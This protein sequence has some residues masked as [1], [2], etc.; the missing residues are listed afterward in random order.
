M[1]NQNDIES[2]LKLGYFLNYKNPRYSFDFSKVDKNKYTDLSFNELVDTGHK[3]FVESIDKVFNENEKHVVPISGGLD[4]RAILAT[5]L[6]FTEASNIRTY[7]FGTPNTF[8]FDIGNKIAKNIGTQHTNYSLIDYK[9]DIEELIDISNRVDHQTIL[10]HHPPIWDILKEFGDSTIW[11]GFL[12]GELTDAR[13]TNYS[14][15]DS[16][17]NLFLR[18]NCYSKNSILTNIDSFETLTKQLSFQ[19]N[20]ELT[21]YEVLDYLNRQLKFIAPHVL[22]KGFKFETPFLDEKV[23]NFYWSIDNKYRENK[24]LYKEILIN[25]HE[26]LFSYPVKDNAGASL[27]DSRAKI[28]ANKVVSKVKRKLSNKNVNV[29]YLDFNYQIREKEDLKNIIQFN[30][31]DLQERDI[32]N[33]IDGRKIYKDHINK[34][35]NYAED[36]LLLTSL[37]IHLKSIEKFNK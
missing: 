19:K 8:D 1:I 26:K 17:E 29:N 9:Y 28:I 3:Y 32:I 14:F 5:L 37:E 24:I 2:F 25:N 6:E 21:N 31:N 13:H 34:V 35:G 10:F 23:L 16:I 36:L 20:I 7:T 12:G 11:S 22:M 30:I 33:G 27:K 15:N 18:K 4:S